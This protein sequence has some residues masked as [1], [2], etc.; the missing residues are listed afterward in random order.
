MV[1]TLWEVMC[2]G[3]I[4]PPI[5]D[6]LNKAH[7]RNNLQIMDKLWCPKS[8]LLSEEYR[9]RSACILNKNDWSCPFG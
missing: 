4:E 9:H 8:R 6:S 5:E 2:D 3:T 7:N 1:Q